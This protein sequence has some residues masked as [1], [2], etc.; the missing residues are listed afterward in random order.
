MGGVGIDLSVLLKPL[1]STPQYIYTLYI[2]VC[3][4]VCT[5]R[6]GEDFVEKRREKLQRWSNRL[7]R[8]PVLSRSEVFIHFIHCDADGVRPACAN[9]VLCIFLY[10]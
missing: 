10:T 8:H 9:I 6:Y 5:G 7:A 3:M 4:C 1:C 2:H